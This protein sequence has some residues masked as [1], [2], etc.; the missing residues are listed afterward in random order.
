MATVARAA[1]V[2]NA[3]LRRSEYNEACAGTTTNP[4]DGSKIPRSRRRPRALRLT[5][6][7]DQRTLVIKGSSP[8][9]GTFALD[10]TISKITGV[11]GAAAPGKPRAP[12]DAKA[13]MSQDTLTI[14]FE[15]PDATPGQPPRRWTCRFSASGTAMDV[16]YTNYLAGGK[17]IKHEYHWVRV[18][19]G[20]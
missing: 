4:S 15:Q 1:L 16:T 18:A 14:D 12:A 10:G 2:I 7:G 3:G 17:E 20:N 19:G 11:G 5:I 13:S 9:V 8:C 6:S